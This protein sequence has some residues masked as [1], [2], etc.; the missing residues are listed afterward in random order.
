MIQD[1]DIR[2]VGEIS[3]MTALLRE[4]VVNEVITGERYVRRG[5]TRSA[6]ITG[7][8]TNRVLAA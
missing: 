3:L 8:S 1:E 5:A 7:C 2:C 4:G 6:R